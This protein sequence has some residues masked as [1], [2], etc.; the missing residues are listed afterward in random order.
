MLVLVVSYRRRSVKFL[1]CVPIR[2]GRLVPDDVD[3]TN[4]N[5]HIL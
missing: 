5:V 1:L 3:P 4:L 2:D